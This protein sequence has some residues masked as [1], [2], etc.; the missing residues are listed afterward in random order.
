[1]DFQPPSSPPFAPPQV[2]AL[3]QRGVRIPFPGTVAIAD[4]VRPDRI[5]PGVVLH[6]GTRLQGTATRIGPG[7]VIGGETPATLIDCVLG[8][9]VA[10]KGGFFE[11]SVFLDESSC[12]SAAHVRPGCLLEE[13][14][15]TAHAVGL[16]QTILFPFVTL[17]SLIN[18]CDVLLTGGTSRKNHSEVGSSFIHFN[19]TPHADKATASRFGDVPSG[20][21]LDQPPTFLGG[22]GGVVG[23]VTTAP[24]TLLAA[25]NILRQSVDTPGQL[26]QC[27]ASTAHQTR[28]FSAHQLRRAEEKLRLNLDYL[29]NLLALALWYRSF[30]L[31]LMAAD[32]FR[33]SCALAAID[34][35]DAAAEERFRQLDKWTALFESCRQPDLA[36]RWPAMRTA[37]QRELSARPEDHRLHTLATA[38]ADRGHSVLSAVRAL[39]PADKH[40]VSSR[41]TTEV[42]RCLSLL[43]RIP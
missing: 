23:P 24:G 42:Q 7:C 14:A 1:M 5:A 6:P 38:A 16:K 37:L 43:E 28:P 30:R 19:F 41:L 40:Q 21:L 36:R 29:G 20:V 3:L 17:G 32:P 15:S 18:F 10:L 9:Q 13:E 2:Q 4:D 33:K 31:P 39:S 11:G 35:L 22:Q 8:H 12:G 27:P 25:G 34:L 26:V